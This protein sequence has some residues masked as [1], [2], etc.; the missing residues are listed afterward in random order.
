MPPFLTGI[1]TLN[2][3]VKN[4]CHILL[5]IDSTY[6]KEHKRLLCRTINNA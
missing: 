3:V 1:F 5:Y 6:L 2:K 4:S